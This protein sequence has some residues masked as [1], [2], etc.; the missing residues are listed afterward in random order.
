MMSGRVST[1]GTATSGETYHCGA[2][3][4]AWRIIV[5]VVQSVG[6]RAAAA[7]LL[8]AKAN[9][10]VPFLGLAFSPFSIL[11]LLLLRLTYRPPNCLFFLAT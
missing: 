4:R 9:A 10:P 1:A 8:H 11:Y 7:V 5:C 2:P 6:P 3:P